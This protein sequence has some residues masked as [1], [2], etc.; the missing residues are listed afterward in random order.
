MRESEGPDNANRELDPLLR[1]PRARPADAL[2]VSER[3]V[4]RR[5]DVYTLATHAWALQANGRA[6]EALKQM[7]AALAVGIRD[8]KLFRQAEVI[9]R[10]AG[11]RGAA[12]RYRRNLATARQT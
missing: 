10:K 2:R 12:A 4:A 9:A 6:A 11:D 1:G 7:E 8:P 3:E 5:S